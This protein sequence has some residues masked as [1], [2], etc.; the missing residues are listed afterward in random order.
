MAKLKAPKGCTGC[1][2]NGEQYPVKKGYVV[3]PD[4]A[5]AEL[6]AHSFLTG[7]D[8]DEAAAAAEELTK[9]EAALEELTK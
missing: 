7:V 3:V 5:V 2:F 6:Q 4:E 9:A 8:E 1:S